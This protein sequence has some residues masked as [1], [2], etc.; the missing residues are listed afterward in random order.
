MT[1][2]LCRG[3]AK[4][5]PTPVCVCCVVQCLQNSTNNNDY[6]TFLSVVL[7]LMVVIIVRYGAHITDI[8]FYQQ[9]FII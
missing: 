9:T 3:L 8:Y 1:V 7:V 4:A 5:L 6:M 2:S